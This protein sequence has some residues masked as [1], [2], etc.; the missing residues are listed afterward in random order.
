MSAV[1][2]VE[3]EEASLLAQVSRNLQQGFYFHKVDNKGL[4][5]SKLWRGLLMMM[6]RRSD[7]DNKHQKRDRDLEFKKRDC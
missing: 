6:G 5:F 1:Q 7:D 3:L 2:A 4:G